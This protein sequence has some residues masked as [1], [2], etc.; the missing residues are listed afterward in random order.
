MFDEHAR[1]GRLVFLQFGLQP[2]KCLCQKNVEA[3]VAALIG[4]NFEHIGLG[5]AIK[6]RPVK[7]LKSVVKFTRNG[8]HGRHPVGF[9]FE[10]SFDSQADFLVH[11]AKRETV[12]FETL[13][14]IMR[15]T[16]RVSW[17]HAVD[18]GTQHGLHHE[19]GSPA[20]ISLRSALPRQ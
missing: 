17:H 6:S 14:S 20:R 13:M 15:G 3:T 11:E 5:G 19:E 10:Q 9:V 2:R 7:V 16:N 12:V 18:I 1:R 4:A 8:G